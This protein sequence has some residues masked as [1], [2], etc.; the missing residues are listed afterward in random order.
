MAEK[1]LS[2][3]D[4]PIIDDNIIRIQLRK[5]SQRKWELRTRNLSP[6]IRFPTIQLFDCDGNLL[7]ETND[8]NVSIKSSDFDDCS[9]RTTKSLREKDFR[10]VINKRPI[11]KHNT[12]SGDNVYT[13]VYRSPH[14]VQKNVSKSYVIKDSDSVTN[15]P[16]QLS[17]NGHNNNCTTSLDTSPFQSEGFSEVSSYKS[18]DNETCEDINRILKIT[19]ENFRKHEKDTTSSINYSISSL[20]E[21]ASSSN[22]ENEPSLHKS[23]SF[24]DST[25]KG[26]PESTLAR[27]K[28]GVKYDF[29][30]NKVSFLNTY[31]KSLP[32]RADSNPEFTLHRRIIDTSN[33]PT[34][35]NLPKDPPKCSKNLED[36]ASDNDPSVAEVNCEMKKRLTMYRR[37]ISEIEPK[38]IV[39]LFAK[40]SN[41]LGRISLSRTSSSESV[42]EA[43]VIG[44]FQILNNGYANSVSNGSPT[45]LD[46]LPVLTISSNTF[47][48]K[49]VFAHGAICVTTH[50]AHSLQAYNT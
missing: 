34:P 13:R 7:I 2:D 15:I 5:S 35:T 4:E 30:H 17:V 37:G 31:L 38:R 21:R 3:S 46:Y 20:T 45:Q 25:I 41:S 16:C 50:K 28:S 49:P 18:S 33:S 19:K 8:E 24:N 6:G 12:I 44:S 42:D 23:Q 29:P 1:D 14:I 47:Y 36:N 39:S 22:K 40:R 27:S 48:E 10:H 11:K 9:L 43:D 32:V 26:F